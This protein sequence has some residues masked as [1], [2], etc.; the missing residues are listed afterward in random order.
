MAVTVAVAVAV[1]TIRQ[2]VDGLLA[3]RE[4]LLHRLDLVPHHLAPAPRSWARR[5]RSTRRST[6]RRSPRHVLSVPLALP[7]RMVLMAER[8]RQCWLPIDEPT[9][10]LWSRPVEPTCGADATCAGC[11]RSAMSQ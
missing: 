11:A 2:D 6:L 5:L 10:R 4:E 3:I 1:R 8:R 7:V 9:V